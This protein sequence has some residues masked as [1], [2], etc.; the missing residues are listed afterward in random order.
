VARIETDPNYTTPTFSR[1]TAATDLFKK[2]DVQNL[3]AAL[4]THDHTSG[5]G[6][7]MLAGSIPNGTI[8][9]AMIADG[10]IT[11]ADLAPNAVTTAYSAQGATGS[12]STT[13]GALVD[14]PEIVLTI[15]G[16]NSADL[17]LCWLWATVWNTLAGG[18]IALGLA[19][20]GAG[21]SLIG[22]FN[23]SG[24]GFAGT[25]ALAHYFGGL[26]GSHTIKGR[27]A[28]TGGGSAVL[29][30]TYRE[31]LCLVVRR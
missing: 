19:L 7:P 2:E 8:T 1:A 27:Y 18:G 9:S 13:S 26:T 28:M 12:P 21:G 14:M 23:S 29:V 3:A 4:S 11:T 22:Q 31:L 6:L 17:V 24:G 10:T 16:L 5:K 15:P 30:G 20:D 25:I